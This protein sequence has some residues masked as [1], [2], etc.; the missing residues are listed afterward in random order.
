[1]AKINQG[2]LGGFSGS[3]GPVIGSSWKGIPY[4]RSKPGKYSHPPTEKQ[5]RYRNKFAAQIAFAKSLKFSVI[6]PI[7]DQKAVMMSGFG[8]FIKTNKDVYDDTGAICDFPSLKLSLG[9]LPLPDNITVANAAG[10]NGAINI[11]WSDNSGVDIAAATDRLRVVALKGN[12]PVVFKEL[13][14]TRKEQQAAIH[15]PYIT[16]DSVHVYLFFQD[17]AE[18]N[19]SECF[20]LP[21]TI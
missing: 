18:T 11:T 17:A 7:W 2:I 13:T 9:D 6:K 21:L 14:F 10:G 15:L 19:Y 16:D 4:I 1:M 12:E 3:V 20:H 5:S 8:L